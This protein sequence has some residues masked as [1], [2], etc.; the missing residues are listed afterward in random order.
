L[1]PAGFFFGHADAALLA[2]ML[3]LGADFV[4]ALPAL[5]AFRRLSLLWVFPI[6]EVYFFLYV[7]IF[8]P[9]SFLSRDVRWKDRDIPR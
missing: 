3:K 6:F 5:I 4:L 7:L 9:I 1:V 2:L 8:P